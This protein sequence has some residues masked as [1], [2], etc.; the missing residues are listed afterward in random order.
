MRIGY[1]STDPGVPYGAGKGASVHVAELTGALAGE[2]VEV[3][4][5]VSS[6]AAGAGPAPAG[7]TVEVLPGPG[8]GSSA[9]DRLAAEADRRAWIEERMARF[10]AHALYERLALHSAA[11]SGAAAR[12]GIPHLVELNAP[13]PDEARRYR[14]LDEPEAAEELERLVLTRASRVLAVSRPLAAYAARRG[15]RRVEV[16]P[17]AVALERYPERRGPAGSEPV[18]LFSGRVR[19]WHGVETIASAWRLLGSA[20]PRLVVA[21]EPG[22]SRALL[23]DVGAELLGALPPARMPAVLARADIGLAP[24]A[25]A[26]P[27]YFSP[28]KLFEYMGAGLAVVA[29]DL[30]AVRDLVSAESA[31]LVPRGDVDALAAAVDGLS[32]DAARRER[33][34]RAARASVAARH[35]W[36][37]R[38]RRVAELAAGAGGDAEPEAAVA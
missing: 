30:P 19:R 24:Y 8:R 2:G 20:A 21:G 31:A 35:T 29:A 14:T 37:H 25:A 28:L 3:L 15:A 26:A 16:F 12:L 7:V 36:R 27:D 6:I 1:L 9:A 18:A 32:A 23:E 13:L 38:A 22:D 34:G 10:G 11:G 33:L 4:A 5:L 17:N